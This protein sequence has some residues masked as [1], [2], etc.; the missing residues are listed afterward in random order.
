MDA[1]TVLFFSA[2]FFI[3]QIFGTAGHL[4]FRVT[5]YRLWLY[6]CEQDLGNSA[7]SNFIKIPPAVLE[8]LQV[9]RQTDRQ[10]D[11]SC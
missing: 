7:V 6:G 8:L 3:A 9:K 5:S 1:E 11:V 4:G 2:D 10:T